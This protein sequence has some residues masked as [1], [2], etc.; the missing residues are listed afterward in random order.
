NLTELWLNWNQIVDISALSNLTNL[1]QLYLAGNQIVDI[2]ALSGLT[3]LTMLGL[4]NN[5]IVDISALSGLTNFTI[6][7]LGSNQIVDVGALV[8]NAGLDAGDSVNIY[9]NYL[10]L[11]PGS[12]DMLDIEALQR[13]GVNVDFDP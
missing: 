10:D 3:N 12:P 4:Y 8:N 5:Q 6:L 13:R 9:Y 1:M 2:S 7:D 11:T